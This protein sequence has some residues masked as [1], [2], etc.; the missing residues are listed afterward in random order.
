MGNVDIK[1]DIKKVKDICFK[2]M[3]EKEQAEA[4]KD[5]SVYITE[6]IVASQSEDLVY[7]VLGPL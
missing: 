7:Q 5:L 2:H 6:C 3:T 4:W 1:V